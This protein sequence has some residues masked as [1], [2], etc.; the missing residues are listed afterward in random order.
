MKC[1]FSILGVLS[2]LIVCACSFDEGNTGMSESTDSGNFSGSDDLETNSVRVRDADSDGHEDDCNDS[3]PTVYAY[4]AIDNDGDGYLGS[5]DYDDTLC[6]GDAPIDHLVPLPG[7]RWERLEKAD[8]DDN[9]PM[10]FEHVCVDADNDGYCGS[11]EE[12]DLLC[13]GADIPAG[14]IKYDQ[15]WLWYDDCNDSDSDVQLIRYPDDDSDGIVSHQSTECVPED[16]SNEKQIRFVLDGDNYDCDD[17][18]AAIAQY[19]PELFGDGVDSNCSGFENLVG[20]VFCSQ[21]EKNCYISENIGTCTGVD[22]G[23]SK[24]IATNTCSEFASVEIANFGVE[25]FNST[26]QVDYLSYIGEDAFI[27]DFGQ[28]FYPA[29]VFSRPFFLDASLAPGQ[30]VRLFFDKTISEIS[31]SSSMEEDCNPSNNTA[32]I[33]YEQIWCD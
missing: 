26:I 33:P 6:I 20:T 29:Q 15:Y 21:R 24:I 25:P 10:L 23:I 4:A 12:E 5:L 27:Y 9:D 16:A 13:M 11:H 18:A 7:N 8:C 14:Y 28:V 17:S 32:K 3:D 31:I 2:F 22:I 1:N 30:E 19:H